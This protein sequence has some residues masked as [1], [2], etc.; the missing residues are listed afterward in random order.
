M[1]DLA[2]KYNG[3]KMGLHP[4]DKTRERKEHSTNIS[5]GF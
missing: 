4:N 3:R 1:I 5:N 2:A